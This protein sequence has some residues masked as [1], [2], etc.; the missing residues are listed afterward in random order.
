MLPQF[1]AE[2]SGL[3]GGEEGVELGQMCQ[4]EATLCLYSLKL[5]GKFLLSL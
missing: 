2:G 1:A 3:E 5:A 4:M